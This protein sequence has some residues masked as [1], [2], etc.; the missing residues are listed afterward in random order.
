MNYGCRLDFKIQH[1][2]SS[3]EDLEDPRPMCNPSEGLI[4]R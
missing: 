4:G 2:K 1:G 3:R